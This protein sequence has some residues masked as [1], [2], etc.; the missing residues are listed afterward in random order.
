MTLERE[1]VWNTNEWITLAIC[2]ITDKWIGRDGDKFA[3]EDCLKHEDNKTYFYE[4]VSK[5][6]IR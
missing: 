3:P 6:Y 1:V 4:E 2:I 5:K